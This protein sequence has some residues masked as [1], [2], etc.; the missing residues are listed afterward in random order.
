[1]KLTAGPTIEKYAKYFDIPIEEVLV[2]AN[3]YINKPEWFPDTEPTAKERAESIKRFIA[4]Q[5]N[6]S[7]NER[8]RARISA[9]ES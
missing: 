1:M 3:S 9:L 8:I 7:I 5:V 4:D 6:G 2:W